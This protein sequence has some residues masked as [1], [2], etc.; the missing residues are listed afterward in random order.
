MLFNSL[1]FLYVF[2]PITYLIYMLLTRKTQRYVWLS[3]TGYVFYAQ[4][5]YKFCFLM[6]FS[7][8][9]SYYAGLGFLRWKDDA[10]MR[11]LCLVLPITVDLSLLGFFKYS[12]FALENLE[13]LFSWLGVN[14]QP[15]HLDVTLPVGISFYTFHTISYIVDSYRGTVK[16]TR[17]FFEF[18]CYVSLFSQLVAG[19]IVRFRQ[20][21]E[22]LDSLGQADR[23]RWLGLGLS[24][25]VFGLVEKVLV[26]DTL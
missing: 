5:N 3:I 10:R 25:F 11:K 18:A 12:N 24:F 13:R 9:V 26:A 4:W 16:P 1:S 19:P 21:E 20:I 2:L 15:P 14:A 17:N 8:L 6:L 7:T 22:D 23:A